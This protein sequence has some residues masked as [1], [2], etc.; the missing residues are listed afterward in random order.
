MLYND[1]DDFISYDNVNI[2]I[3]TFK[4]SYRNN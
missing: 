3:F 1:G 2:Q 4:I